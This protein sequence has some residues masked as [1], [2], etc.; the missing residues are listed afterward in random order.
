VLSNSKR[1]TEDSVT[2]EGG[3][4]GSGLE[5][6]TGTRP[7]VGGGGSPHTSMHSLQ[8]RHN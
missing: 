4:E 5:A 7:E 2:A 8:S 6:T 1:T 3:K